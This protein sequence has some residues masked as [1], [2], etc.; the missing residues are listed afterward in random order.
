MGSIADV[1]IDVPRYDGSMAK[2]DQESAKDGSG[3]VIARNRKASHQFLLEETLE[4]GLE[5]RGSE[6]KVL[7]A[8]QVSIEEAYAQILDGELWLIGMTIPGYEAASWTNHTP[9]RQRKLLVHRRELEKLRQRV[10]QK[11]KTL[12]PLKLYFNERGIAKLTIAVASGKKLHDKRDAIRE[13]EQKRDIMR[14]MR[15]S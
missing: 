5:L 1:S 7:R 15:R 8:G 4:C 10:E 3:K 9:K 13:R 11:K 6:V 2:G 14:A 12:V